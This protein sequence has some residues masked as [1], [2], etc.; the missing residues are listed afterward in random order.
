MLA[1]HTPSPLKGVVRSE[2]LDKMYKEWFLEVGRWS[3]YLPDDV[4][5]NSIMGN[6]NLLLYA[7]NFNGVPLDTHAGCKSFFANIRPDS[8]LKVGTRAPSKLLQ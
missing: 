1:M 5:I 8:R 2:F 3:A 6:K 7:V 4:I